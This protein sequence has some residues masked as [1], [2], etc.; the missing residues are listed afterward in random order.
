MEKFGHSDGTYIGTDRPNVCAILYL[1]DRKALVFVLGI[2]GKGGE[3]LIPKKVAGF[4][5]T[6]PPVFPGF[7][8]LSST[9]HQL[10]ISRG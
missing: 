10:V 8:P 5:S 1:V 7:I 4:L 2:N 3:K 9:Y 6:S